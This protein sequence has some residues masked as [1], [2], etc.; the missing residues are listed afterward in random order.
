MTYI[1]FGGAVPELNG[2]RRRRQFGPV[3]VADVPAIAHLETGAFHAKLEATAGR[4]AAHYGQRGRLFRIARPIHLHLQ[5]GAI[6]SFSIFIFIKAYYPILQI[7][8]F[9][10]CAY[11]FLSF[12]F[13]LKVLYI[14]VHTLYFF[15]SSSL[16]L[17]L[18]FIKKRKKVSVYTERA[19]G[20]YVS[21]DG[22]GL[23]RRRRRFIHRV[24]REN[25]RRRRRGGW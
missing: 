19:L 7:S 13:N 6:Y 16:S 11:Y 5:V 4:H 17:S 23:G 20:F 10:S 24:E 9:H 1:Q 22:S 18:S 14:Y 25:Q 12:F 2:R 3:G 21:I 8:G 15:I